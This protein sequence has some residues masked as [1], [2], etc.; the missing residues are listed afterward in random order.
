[1]AHKVKKQYLMQ[2]QYDWLNSYFSFILDSA[3]KSLFLQI[4]RRLE[5]NSTA[6]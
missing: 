2:L 4:L 1:M 6:S 5:V 3:S